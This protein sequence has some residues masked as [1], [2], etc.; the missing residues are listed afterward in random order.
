MWRL[1]R[2]LGMSK[3]ELGES[4]VYV[5]DGYKARDVLNALVD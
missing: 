3:A 4:L 1:L 2:A 5:T